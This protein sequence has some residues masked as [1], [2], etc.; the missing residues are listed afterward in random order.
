MKEM[1]EAASL[2]Y[3]QAHED[4]NIIWGASID[5]SMG[6]MVKVTVIATGFDRDLA[7]IQSEQHA[8][9]PTM[10]SVPQQIAAARAPAVPVQRPAM[11]VPT[12]EPSLLQSSR[13]PQ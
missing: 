4:A 7:E 9:R 6:D 11:S 5:E 12:E 2:I 1:E 8:Q 3:E 10:V 13:R